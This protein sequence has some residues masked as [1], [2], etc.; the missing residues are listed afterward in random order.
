M[1]VG[2]LNMSKLKCSVPVDLCRDDSGE[3]S[4][5][6]CGD[7]ACYGFTGS[8]WLACER[9][10]NLYKQEYKD[11]P[12]YKLDDNDNDDREEYYEEN[13]CGCKKINGV[14]QGERSCC[15]CK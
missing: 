14:S 6:E 15:S 10:G 7:D 4:Y 11:F 3:L 8:D 13:K 5:V 12:I 1:Y 2:E 9:H